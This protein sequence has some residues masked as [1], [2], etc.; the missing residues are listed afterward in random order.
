LPKKQPQL[1]V[2]WI[3]DPDT[4]QH[5]YG[6]GSANAAGGLRSNDGMLGQL[7]AKLQEL[8]MDRS[9]D[10]IVVSDHGH[11]NVSGSQKLFP[12]RAVKDGQI[13]EVDPHGYSVSGLVRLADV[14]HRAGFTVFDGIGCTYLPVAL[15]IKA[16]GS[17]VYPV[18]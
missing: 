4:S 9:T 6:V 16:D 18:E 11:S 8:G 3:R 13:G 10:I 7:R 17:P 2:V 12:L 15:G 5:T 1:S 14:M